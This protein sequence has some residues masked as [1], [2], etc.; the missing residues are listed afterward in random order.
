VRLLGRRR[1][2]Y[3]DKIRF[4]LFILFEKCSYFLL[5]TFI[6]FWTC[7]GRHGMKEESGGKKVDQF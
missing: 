1:P 6:L 3:R 7:A 4:I 5:S 2:Q